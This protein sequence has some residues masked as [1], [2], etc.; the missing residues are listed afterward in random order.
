MNL[1]KHVNL[2][3]LTETFHNYYY[4]KGLSGSW[5]G[6]ADEIKWIPSLIT[7][8]LIV[9]ITYPFINASLYVV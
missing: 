8:S 9:V 6:L 2:S 4:T 3:V 5:S 1:K 7:I